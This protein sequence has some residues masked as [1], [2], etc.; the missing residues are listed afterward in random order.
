MIN[1]L[2]AH[3]IKAIIEN[4]SA[5]HNQ[6]KLEDINISKIKNYKFGHFQLIN[7]EYL[8]KLLKL[9]NV[10][11]F[12]LFKNYFIQIQ[13]NVIFINSF[14]IN[15]ILS[16]NFIENQLIKLF[17]FKEEFKIKE[18]IILDYSGPNIAKAMH[19]GH[20]RSTIVGDC[21]S[22]LFEFVGAKIIKINHLGDW[23]TQFGMLIYYLKTYYYEK[24]SKL[25][26]KDLSIFYKNAYINFLNDNDFNK[27]A[28]IEVIKL[29]NKDKE[30]INIWKNITRISKLEYDKI[31]KLLNIKLKYKGESFYAYLLNP[32]VKFFEKKKLITISDGAKCIYLNNFKNRDN[33]LL[34]LIIQKSDGG[35][36][37][38][39]T[40][41]AALYYRIKYHK[42]DKIIYVTDIGQKIHFSML[43]NIIELSKINIQNIK[44]IHIPLGLMLNSDGKK[45]KTREGESER[46]IDFIRTA[47]KMSKKIILVKNK[48]ISN[49]DL[50]ITSKDLAINT[51]KYADLSNK[52]ENNYIFNYDTM[53]KFKGN[54]A[55]FLIYAY[56]RVLGILKKV[57]KDDINKVA[58]MNDINL[59]EKIEIELSLHLLQYNYFLEKAVVKLD[60]NILTLYLYQLAEIFHSFFHVCNVLNSDFIYSRILLCKIIK[61]IF[62]SIFKILGFNLI[63]K[64]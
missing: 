42:P 12:N 43:F 24:K 11:L 35:F 28:K 55:A 38:A 5:L 41:L 23:G 39:T 25:N 48:F 34:P 32:I 1:K 57:K 30:T 2:R 7:I 16:N 15:F 22:N 37:Y 17:Q 53:L 3:C 64:L 29:Q 46:L 18:K 20:L 4:F 6:I 31:Y 63:T 51:I 59:K 27:R 60:T 45:I 10:D 33:N 52:L 9:D 19:V 62:E 14:F 58:N 44:L 36:N 21:L 26:L 13:I 56:V 40:D 8:S 50:H 47:I 54:T 49:K 61:N